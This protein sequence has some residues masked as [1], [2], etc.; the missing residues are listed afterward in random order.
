MPELTVEVVAGMA[1]RLRAMV[2]AMCLADDL[3]MR[4]KV[5]WSPNSPSCMTLFGTLFA[6]ESLPSWVT[7]VIGPMLETATEVLSPQD[8][9]V[10][11]SKPPTPIRSYGHFYQKD[12]PRWLNYLRILQPNSRIK[13]PFV[14]PNTV[15]IHIRRGDHQKSKIYSPLT[16]FISVMQAEPP[17]TQFIVATDS[18]VDKEALLNLFGQRVT[19]PAVNLSRMTQLGMQSAMT[20]FISLSR[21]CKIFGSYQS[22]FS[23]IAA[24]YGGVPLHV[25]KT[26]D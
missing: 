23:E 9:E 4:L 21:C 11:L 10:W 12:M 19:F 17:N 26:Q 7:V 16:S 20:D 8:L 18:Q 1:N 13:L 3:K 22:S 24:L 2:S 15:G 5:I 6:I 25:I 14:T